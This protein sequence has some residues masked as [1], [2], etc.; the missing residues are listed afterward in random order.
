MKGVMGA[1]MDTYTIATMAVSTAVFWL[2]ALILGIRSKRRSQ[3]QTVPYNVQSPDLADILREILNLFCGFLLFALFSFL[4]A[5]LTRSVIL[6]IVL[7]LP[8][9]WISLWCAH[10]VFPRAVNPLVDHFTHSDP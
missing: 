7:H 1:I 5:K 8:A 3:Q 4:I 2:P 10:R 9:W 6:S